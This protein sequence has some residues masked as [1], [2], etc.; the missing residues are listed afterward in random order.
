MHESKISHLN[1]LINKHLV[2]QVSISLTWVLAAPINIEPP[3]TF[4]HFAPMNHNI[5]SSNTKFHFVDTDFGRPL[6]M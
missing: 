1:I 4:G 2:I 6:Q 3:N 5:S